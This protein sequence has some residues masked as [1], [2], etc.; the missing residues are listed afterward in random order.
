MIGRIAQDGRRYVLFAVPQ[1]RVALL[2]V[3]SRVHLWQWS[4]GPRLSGA[5]REVA[6]LTDPVTPTW[7]VNVK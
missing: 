5:L 6:A 1:D 3:G 7:L 2:R 4:D